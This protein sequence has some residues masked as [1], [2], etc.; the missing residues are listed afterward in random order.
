[1]PVPT[2]ASWHESGVISGSGVSVI[3]AKS[4]R[5]KHERNQTSTGSGVSSKSSCE[6]K[7]SQHGVMAIGAKSA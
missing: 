2:S 3:M 4:N 1:M 5:R 7:N 6:N